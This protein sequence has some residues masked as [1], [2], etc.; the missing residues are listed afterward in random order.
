MDL[1]PAAKTTDG[2]FRVVSLVLRQFSF[3]DRVVSG[4]GCP[5]S[6]RGARVGHDGA[7]VIGADGPYG[8]RSHLLGLHQDSGLTSR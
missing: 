6:V 1:Q 4:A 2:G 5:P 3:S 7:S 8:R